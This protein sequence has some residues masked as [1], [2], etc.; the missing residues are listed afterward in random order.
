MSDVSIDLGSAL[1]YLEDKFL[2]LLKQGPEQRVAGELFKKLVQQGQRDAST[3]QIIGMD[4]PIAIREIYQPV[5]LVPA[6]TEM[7]VS[8][9]EL[10]RRHDDAIILAAP[11]A[12][13]TVFLHHTFALAANSKEVVPLFISLRWSNAVLDLTEFLKHLVRGDQPQGRKQRLL[14]LLD[15]F[16][17]ISVGERQAVAQAVTTFQSLGLGNVYLTCRLHYDTDGLKAQ[18]F[19]IS[20]FTHEQSL[21]FVRGFARAYG[22]DIQPTEL[23]TELYAHRFG[24]FATNPLMLALVCILKSGPMPRLPRTAVG[25]IQRA[26]DTLTFR[27]DEA[28]GIWRESKLPLDGLHRLSLLK[29]LAFLLSPDGASR[30]EVESITRDFLAAQ[31]HPNLSP[32][33]LLAEIAQWY[34][35][36]VPIT[37]DRWMFAHKTIHD[38]LAAQY[39]VESGEFAAADPKDWNVRSA[40][41]A[42]LIPDATHAL[43]R[44]LNAR[45]DLGAF[46]E[47][48]FNQPRFEPIL[49]A[50]AL[51]D[52][53]AQPY[54]RLY[55]GS[56]PAVMRCASDEF[57]RVIAATALKRGKSEVNRI[58]LWWSLAEQRYRGLDMEPDVIPKAIAAYE[59]TSMHVVTPD[60]FSHN[61]KF[62]DIANVPP[63]EWLFAKSPEP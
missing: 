34:G 23:L 49:V 5:T 45:C 10:L 17:E 33:H 47:C 3:I 56:P 2:R 24:D 40:Y 35:M 58:V 15:G 38:F 61:V 39:W 19:R 7:T 62:S 53:L 12:G 9:A 6:R 13:K 32:P 20:L 4:R 46:A 8:A 63:R 60:G 43:V 14:L 26:I 27:W 51:L 52:N 29:R 59:D 48:L 22:A 37:D 55:T 1:P 21:S 50:A 25:L 54:G 36:F 31:H 30:L 42:C 18:H 28:R 41:A 16:D 11:G 57:L 44:A